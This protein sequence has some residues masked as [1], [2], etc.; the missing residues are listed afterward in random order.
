M[1]LWC[2]K[3]REFRKKNTPDWH[4][5]RYSSRHMM[6]PGHERMEKEMRQARERISSS[7]KP[8]DE[9]LKRLG[10]LEAVKNAESDEDDERGHLSLPWQT[11]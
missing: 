3:C 7:G 8:K 4:E 11:G 5:C 2:T 6:V 10:A 9:D 1:I